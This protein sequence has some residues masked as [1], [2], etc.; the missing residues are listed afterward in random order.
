VYV[1]ACVCDTATM[2]LCVRENVRVCVCV[3]MCV[4]KR[5]CLFVWEWQ[6]VFEREVCVRAWMLSVR[7]CVCVGGWVGKRERVCVCDRW[8]VRASVYMRVWRWVCVYACVGERKRERERGSVGGCVRESG[9]RDCRFKGQLLNQ[10][11]RSSRL[12]YKGHLKSEWMPEGEESG[13]R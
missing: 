8:G 10:C 9:D 3:C 13:S 5:E 6:R 11:L 2:C 1:C 4:E 12:F 7:A